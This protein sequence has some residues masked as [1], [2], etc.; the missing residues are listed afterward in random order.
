MGDIAWSV[1]SLK[2]SIK[3]LL[4]LRYIHMIKF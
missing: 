3:T 2:I 4:L 1:G